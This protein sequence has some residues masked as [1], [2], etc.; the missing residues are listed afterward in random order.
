MMRT[1]IAIAL[2]G[3]ALCTTTENQIYTL[4]GKMADINNRWN[5]AGG[6]NDDDYTPSLDQTG[7]A[8]FLPSESSNQLD[9]AVAAGTKQMKITGVQLSAGTVGNP[10]IIGLAMRNT[11]CSKG[12]DS[13][14]AT[15][16]LTVTNAN[17][18]DEMTFN[19]PTGNCRFNG[20]ATAVK[21]WNDIS[22][23]LETSLN[24]NGYGRK[25]CIGTNAGTR[26]WAGLYVKVAWDCDAAGGV[27]T[28]QCNSF[29]QTQAAYGV[30]TALERAALSNTV[31]TTCCKSNIG[32]NV[33]VC[34]NPNAEKCCGGNPYTAGGKC[35][36]STNEYVAWDYNPCPCR[37]ENQVTD[38]NNNARVIN[39]DCAEPLGNSSNTQADLCCLPTKFS[40]F[41]AAG[42]NPA[43]PENGIFGTCYKEN[44]HD[45]CCNTGEVYD[46]GMSQCCSIN[47]VQSVDIPCPC[48]NDAQ[49][50]GGQTNYAFTTHRCCRA[51]G[52]DA[53]TPWEQEQC[54]AYANMPSIP[55]W[56]G[57]PQNF[58]K[59]VV[60]SQ[61]CFGQCI[62]TNFQICCNGVACVREYEKC[63]NTTCCNKFVGTCE[64]GIRSVSRGN[65]W[66]WNDFRTTFSQCTT[67]EHL[68]PIKTFLIFG[69]PVALLAASLLSLAVVLIFANKASNRSYSFIETAMIVLAVGVV[70]FAMPTFFSPAAKYGLIVAIAALLTILSAAARIKA[71]NVGLL[72]VQ[73]IV[74]LYLIDPFG[75]NNYLNFTSFRNWGNGAPNGNTNGILHTTNYMWTNWGGFCTAYY[76]YFAYDNQL[77]DTDRFDNPTIPTFGY[78]SRAW[79][80]TLLIFE[81]ILIM[82]F[83]IMFFVT[84]LAL[85]LR[86][87]KEPELAPIEL[88]VQKLDDMYD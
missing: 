64:E 31:R 42:A 14:Y 43:R 85:V 24:T 55:T 88:E 48:E 27:A 35:C 26:K 39:T 8:I 21:C 86:F 46:P 51:T 30:L 6:T 20:G 78:C 10:Y 72:F 32:L 74:I 18:R 61:R 12:F 4:A 23:E 60:H 41:N 45:R 3:L 70:L 40:E 62:D 1:C 57:A 68:H 76:N 22:L 87:R 17:N 19:L 47:G 71:L 81:S 29:P 77:R 65:P 16:A 37:A 58:G 38:P 2:F 13:N 59:G 56:T 25:L 82:L 80:A 9:A 11:D 50:A 73:L 67:I 66:N 5:G 49:C 36:S 75:G 79:V 44:G 28:K 83:F 84:L 15:A 7:L 53:M 63:C 33:G 52:P 54:S 34:I 69:I